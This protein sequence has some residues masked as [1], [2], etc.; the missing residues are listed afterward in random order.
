L[1][2]APNLGCRTHAL[3][4]NEY[5]CRM[6]KPQV[7]I[8]D[9]ESTDAYTIEELAFRHRISRRKAYDEK[10]AGRLNFRKVGT[11]TIITKEDAE[12]WRRALPTLAAA[13]A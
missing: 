9:P 3:V 2:F 6:R 13:T 10:I 7:H 11:R 1:N 5:G 4:T 12:A 8:T